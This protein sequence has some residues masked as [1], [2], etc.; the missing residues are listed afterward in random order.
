MR[1]TKPSTSSKVLIRPG[2]E[3]VEAVN[4][5]RASVAI[6]ILT[7]FHPRAA[8][9]RSGVDIR[10]LHSYMATGFATTGFTIG[11]ASHA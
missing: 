1:R 9:G 3:Y 8:A 5:I 7:C 6:R 2:S 11:Y 10:I 4:A